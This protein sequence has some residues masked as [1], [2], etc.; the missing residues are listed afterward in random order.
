MTKKL[1]T[2][3]LILF[4][5]FIALNIIWFYGCYK[6]VDVINAN[7]ANKD[8]KIGGNTIRFSKATTSGYPNKIS[9]NLEN[10]IETTS[11]AVLKYNK[12]VSVGYNIT[13]QKLFLSYEGDVISKFKNSSHQGIKV[14]GDFNYYIFYPITPAL[15]KTLLT[16][17]DYFEL[18]NYIRNLQIRFGKARAF[19]LQN[20][21]KI[22][23]QDHFDVTLSPESTIYYKSLPEFLNNIPKTFYLEASASVNQGTN[24]PNIPLSLIFLHLPTKILKFKV[25]SIFTTKAEKLKT[26]D[27]FSDFSLEL[28]KYN[29]TYDTFESKGSI[30]LKNYNRAEQIKIEIQSH[31]ETFVKEPLF[32]I[33]KRKI[34][35]LSP[36]LRDTKFYAQNVTVLKPILDNPEKYIPHLHEFGAMKT[37]IDLKFNAKDKV[38]SLNIKKFVFDSKPYTL[39]L[40]NDTNVKAD[41]SWTSKGKIALKQYKNFVDLI[42]GYIQ[43]VALVFSHLDRSFVKISDKKFRDSVKIFLRK[44]SNQPENNSDDLYFDIDLSNNYAK[45]RIG[46]VSM[47]DAKKIYAQII[48]ENLMQEF[49][50]TKDPKKVLDKIAPDLKDK[51]NELIDKFKKEQKKIN[52]DMLKK[53]FK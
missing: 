5:S 15:V 20:N 6:V 16:T 8:L 7:F 1:K 21:A 47:D 38:S 49:L 36:Q 18:V 51:G 9:V 50:D 48:A 40:N 42:I 37:D 28:S 2:L 30:L 32:Q 4:V 26:E 11:G 27:I 34:E 52:P 3:F 19:D 10:F 24:Q 13:T 17:K 22:L 31:A 33:F 44:I 25:S 45:A 41:L 39:E 53:L 46:S 43:R 14:Q 23:D 35:L 29:L 12:P